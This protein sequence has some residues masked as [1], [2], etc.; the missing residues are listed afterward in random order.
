LPEPEIFPRFNT[1]ENFDHTGIEQVV[2][3]GDRNAFDRAII[4]APHSQERQIGFSM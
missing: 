3:I 4:A 2:F 1:M